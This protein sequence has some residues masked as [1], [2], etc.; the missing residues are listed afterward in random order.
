MNKYLKKQF[1]IAF[2]FLIVVVI[3]VGGIWLLVKPPRATCFDEKQNQGEEDIDCGGPCGF[4]DKPMDLIILSQEF[5]PT[6]EGSFDFVAEIKNPN[7]DWGVEYIKY[8]F[9][10]YDKNDEQIG[11]KQ[12]ETWFLP[13][14]TK[15]IIEQNIDF[16]LDRIDFQIRNLVWQKLEDFRELEIR[17]NNSGTRLLENN[18]TQVFG[19]VENKSNYDLNTIE[20]VGVL[21]DGRDIVAAGKTDM[22]TVLMGETRYFELNWPFEISADDLELKPYTNIYLND[23]FLKAHGTLERFQEY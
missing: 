15:Y 22:N 2:F 12:G 10:A 6:V 1:T 7:P 9:Y 19:N 11:F 4:C 23:N 14:E 20:V 18:H 3:I 8:R 5:I 21:L 17:I 16:D 13:Q